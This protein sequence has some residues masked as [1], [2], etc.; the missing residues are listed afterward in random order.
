MRKCVETFFA[1]FRL[2]FTFIHSIHEMSVGGRSDGISR[3]IQD[4]TGVEKRLDP[5]IRESV[6][7]KVA[8]IM[9]DITTLSSFISIASTPYHNTHFQLPASLHLCA[10]V[11]HGL[12]SVYFHNLLKLISLSS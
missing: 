8:L 10:A 3:W 5:W 7:L 12:Y 4:G 1:L 9:T 11:H 6:S 2:Y